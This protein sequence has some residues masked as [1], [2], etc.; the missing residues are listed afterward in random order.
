MKTKDSLLNDFNNKILNVS[1]RL[2]L[3]NKEKNISINNRKV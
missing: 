2:F 3:I 1:L